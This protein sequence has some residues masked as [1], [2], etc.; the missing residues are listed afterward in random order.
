MTIARQRG[1]TTVEFAFVGATALL[2]L[3]SLIEFGRAMFVLN[4]LNEATRRAARMASV[5]PVNDP[6]AAQVGMFNAPG[7]TGNTIVGGLTPANFSIQYLN[8]TG[9]VVADPVGNFAQI[10]FVRARIVNFQHRMLIPFVNYL[11]TTPEFATT[12]RRESLG[13]PR[14]GVVEPC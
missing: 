11:F 9:A 14:D 10:E 6:A 4:A 1:L 2:L 5:C 7:E 8:A 12:V 13:V 3:F